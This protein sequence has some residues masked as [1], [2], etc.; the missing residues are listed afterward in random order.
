MEGKMTGEQIVKMCNRII[1]RQDLDTDLLL[2][3]INQQRKIVFRS[4]YLYKIQSWKRNIEPEDGFCTLP[5][6]KQARYVEWTPDTQD[7]LDF[8][9]TRK[10]KLFRLNTINEAYEVY[11]DVDIIGEPLHYVVMQNGIKVIPAPTVGVVNIFGEWYPEDIKND[12]AEDPLTREVSD[13]IIY[14]ACAEYF[15]FLAEPDKATL[16]RNKGTELIK[17]YLLE[18]KRQMTDDKEMYARDPFG[19]LGYIHGTRREQ[20]HVYD[21]DELTGGTLGDIYDGGE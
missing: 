21:V 16:W 12:N 4:T 7:N 1:K 20:G 3:L 11:D 2:M 19:N 15:D 14:L 9:S 17:A 18:I 8:T 6:L 10:K 13:A 5:T